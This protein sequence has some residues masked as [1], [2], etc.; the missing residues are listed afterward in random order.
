MSIWKQ[1]F[2]LPEADGLSD[3]H[4]GKASALPNY[5]SQTLRR[6]G[7]A[8]HDEFEGPSIPEAVASSRAPVRVLVKRR[9]QR[10]ARRADQAEVFACQP[11]IGKPWV[12]E[13]HN[14]RIETMRFRGSGLTHKLAI[15]I[16]VNNHL[17]RARAGTGR[18]KT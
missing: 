3:D 17:R 16:V 5:S 4:L 13:R 6:V 14:A 8:R 15:D 18:I 9:R 7:T 11:K 10:E 12:N 1:P 2:K